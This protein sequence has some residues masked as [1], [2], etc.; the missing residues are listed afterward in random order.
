MTS[1]VPFWLS[2]LRRSQQ[3]SSEIVLCVPAWGEPMHLEY[4]T[5][6][7]LHLE[8]STCSFGFGVLRA[9]QYNRT[10][11]KRKPGGMKEKGMFVWSGGWCAMICHINSM[12]MIFGTK[13]ESIF[14]VHDVFCHFFLT[15][16]HAK[17]KVHYSKY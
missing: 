5:G 13:V 11:D 17:K 6:E 15:V 10:V 1:Y 3:G 14:Y 16:S 9:A 2:H 4:R 8:D 12:Y 7:C